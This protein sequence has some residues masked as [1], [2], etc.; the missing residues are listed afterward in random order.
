MGKLGILN[1]CVLVCLAH[2]ERNAQKAKGNTTLTLVHQSY[3]ANKDIDKKFQ[4]FRKKD[5]SKIILDDN[6]NPD[7]RKKITYKMTSR[8]ELNQ[9]YLKS[10]K[11]TCEYLT[12]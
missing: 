3:R 2:L 10:I 5:L 1:E 4:K 12:A 11:S 8:N 9:K 7:L 6:I